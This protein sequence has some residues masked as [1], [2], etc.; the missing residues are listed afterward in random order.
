[1]V[2]I[3]GRQIGC[4]SSK[5]VNSNLFYT[6]MWPIWTFVDRLVYSFSK[7]LNYFPTSIYILK[8][9]RLWPS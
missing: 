4:N 6:S 5:A 9:V 2:Q 7:Y 8:I 1:M 3:I